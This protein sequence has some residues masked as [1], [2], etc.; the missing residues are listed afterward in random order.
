VLG[1][2]VL[3][4]FCVRVYRL[5]A[6]GL[7][8]DEAN[9]I[10][11]LRCYAH[12]DIT[13]NGEHPMLMKL[14]CYGSITTA[15]AWNRLAGERGVLR[16]SEESALRFPSVFFGALTVVPL[17]LLASILLG[18]RVA[19]VSAAFWALGL[20]AIW[21]NRIAKE[22]TLLV[23]FMLSGYCLYAMAKRHPE[24]DSRGAERL[25]GMAGAA[26]GMMIA[27]K[28]FVHYFGLNFLYYKLVGYDSRNNRPVDRRSWSYFFG[29]MILSLFALNPAIV[30]PQTWRYLYRYLS[31]ELVTH[32]GYPIADKLFVNDV[33]QTPFGNAWYFYLLFLGVKIPLP[34]L[35]AFAAGL[36][37]V[38][39]QRGFY[40]RSRGYL[41][42][43]LM[44]IFWLLPMSVVGTKFL[45]YSLALMP[46]VY[47]TSAVGVVLLWR[48]LARGMERLSISWATSRRVAAAASGILFVAAPAL[49]SCQAILTSQPGLYMN[50]IAGG[51]VGYFFPHDELY[52]LGARESIKYVADN[53]PP[54][55]RLAS[56]IPGVVEY[57]LE[58]YGRSDIRSEIIS[59]PRFDLNSG[60]PDYVILQPGRAYIENLP[61]FRFIENNWEVVQSSRYEGIAAA[62]VYRAPRRRTGDNLL[63]NIDEK[64]D[65]QRR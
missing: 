24:S 43:R 21:F 29:A 14:M 15:A 49:S 3:V 27:S 23:F 11:A 51:K 60:A 59:Q 32:H 50:Q 6:A 64:A 33:S 56:E 8:E 52:D 12:G 39:R 9:K 19:L 25:Y 36:V 48:L 61:N 5:D 7:A 58:R 17:F 45:R 65:S 41:F 42:L 40:P 35:V 1:I 18:E 54:G 13:V 53:A 55:A 63:A 46:L 57:Y 47:V 2:A 28:Y 38:F 62:T 20:D 31:E 26:F 34:I 22:D 16:I 30:I 44:L 10:L 37:E 4:G